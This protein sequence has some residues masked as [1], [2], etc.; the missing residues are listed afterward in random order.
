[1]G[2]KTVIGIVF[3]AVIVTVLVGIPKS[4]RTIPPAN[5][6]DPERLREGVVKKVLIIGGGLAGMSAA[7]DLAERGYQVTLHEADS[8]LGGV[9]LQSKPVQKLGQTFIVDRGMQAWFHNF[10]NA[11]DMIRRLGVE[12]NF[13]RWEAHDVVYRN[14]KP[15]RMYSHGIFPLNLAGMI[16]RSPNLNL[17]E[18][19]L[20]LR[21]AWDFINYNHDTNFKRW[22]S[23]SFDEY[24]DMFDIHRGFYDI[25]LEP[26]MKASYQDKSTFSAAEMF[27]FSHMFYVSNPQADYRDIAK[28]NQATAIINPWADKLR[29]LGVK[30]EME[31]AVESLIFDKKGK[32]V[33]DSKHPSEHYDHVIL[34][35]GLNST[36]TILRNSLKLLDDSK[37]KSTHNRLSK[38]LEKH[39]MK[40]PLAPPFKVLTVWF[41]KRLESKYNP[42]IVQTPSFPPITIITQYHK[43]REDY[44]QWANQS[45]GSVLAFLMFAWEHGEVADDKLWNFIAPTVREIFPEIFQRGFKVLAYHVDGSA[46]YPSYEKGLAKYRPT[47]TF[48]KECGFPNLL[49]AGNWLHAN[50]PTALIERPIATGREAANQILLSDHVRQSSLIVTDSH[51]PGFFQYM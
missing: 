16:F 36:K 34:A 1:M 49:F 39:L 8:A 30:I 5:P 44:A 21:C 46:T 31:S 7:L 51:G 40:L 37:D 4:P 19:L 17:L 32:I 38:V 24:M 47:V 50:Y 43:I 26:G 29:S 15:E 6:D 10:H 35:A 42:D 12:D 11:W 41:D 25:V 20:W 13:R 27:L 9:Y 18:I 45:G 33:T 14:Y 22:D 48:P 2:F 3:V 23:I 28:M